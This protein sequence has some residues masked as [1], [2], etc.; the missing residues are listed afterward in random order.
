MSGRKHFSKAAFV[1]L[2]AILLSSV[3]SWAQEN[4]PYPTGPE[5]GRELAAKLRAIKPEENLGW[6]GV[7]K[8]FGRQNKL[9]P[10]PVSCQLTVSETNWT[11]TYTT[12]PTDTNLAEK[13]TIIF[14]T[15]GLNQYFYARAIAPGESPGKSKQVTAAE[16]DVPIGGS[17]FWLSDLGLEFLHWPDQLRLK[18][19]MRSS[20][21]CFVL[22]STNPHPVR[23]GYSRV[24]TWIEKESGQP[25]EAEAYG[26]DKTNT[27]VKSFS[28]E[29][30]AKVDGQYQVKE[31]EINGEGHFWTRLEID[32][33]A[34]KAK[35]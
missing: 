2:T 25:L 30:V 10:V 29:K 35:H 13:F 1:L 6:H 11:V 28:L 19:E 14:S 20:R 21:P 12:A 7:L 5:A 8:I 24:K 3:F 17:D 33:E 32:V 31:M 23:G 9:R 4:D 16:A 34:D 27:V 26:S 15:N 22:I 18:G